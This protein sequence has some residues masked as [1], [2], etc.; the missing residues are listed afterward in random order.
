[1]GILHQVYEAI[2][3]H[4]QSQSSVWVRNEKRQKQ[5]SED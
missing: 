1:M 2:Y 4:V 3:Y 5:K